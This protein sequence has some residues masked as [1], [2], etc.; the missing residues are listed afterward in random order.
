M[1]FIPRGRYEIESSA[2]G[3]NPWKE[4]IQIK[5]PIEPNV[6]IVLNVGTFVGVVTG[7]WSE[8]PLFRAIA[9]E[10]NETVKNAIK[11]GF[12][13][14]TRDS[15]NNTALHVAVEHGNLE[16]V[17]LLLES[18]ANVNI[19]NKYKLTPIW[20]FD[21]EEEGKALEIFRL[22]IAKGADVN[23]PNEDKETLLMRACEDDNLEVVKL[24]LKAGANPNLK[25]DE[26]D[27]T[28]F[29]LTDSDE[30]KQLLKQY[31]AK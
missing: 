10:D 12:K 30:I 19:K 8:I 28:A 3:F 29:E 4:V 26:D 27:E 21:D 5:E 7:N 16:I 22:L 6:K 25:F 20:M 17:K 23:L 14:N 1:N 2:N 31:G 13:V 18:G 24:L 9:Q 11:S 15:E